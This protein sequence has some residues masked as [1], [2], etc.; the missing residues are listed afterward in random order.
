MNYHI[1]GQSPDGNSISVVMH[2]P[3]PNINNDVGVSYRTA[4]L[5][6]QGGGDIESVMPDISAAEQAA[7]NAGELYEVTGTLSTNPTETTVEKLAKLD[8]M[9]LARR[10]RVYVEFG[11]QLKYF[12]F[13]R[14]VSA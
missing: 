13:A 2:I 10:D 3:V 1:R 11:F 5:L 14:N 7:L 8:A 6:M 9:W 12:G 4:I